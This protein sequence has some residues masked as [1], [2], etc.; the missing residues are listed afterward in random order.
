MNADAFWRDDPLTST[1][2]DRLGTAHV[3]RFR[4]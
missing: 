3:G 2:E 4:L 1:A